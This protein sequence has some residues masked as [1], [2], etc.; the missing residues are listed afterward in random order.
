MPRA[1]RSNGAASSLGS[2]LARDARARRRQ[3]RAARVRVRN[4]RRRAA[5]RAAR[6]ATCRRRGGAFEWRRS[7]ATW[8]SAQRN[9]RSF[10]TAQGEARPPS[11]RCRKV[12][13][14][15]RSTRTRRA[16]W[17][18][19]AH[20]AAR[21]G[22]GG[23]GMKEVSA[24][25][26]KL[27]ARTDW[28]F[29][30]LD[31]TV[32]ALPQGE[33]RVAVEIAGDEVTAAYRFVFVPEEW[34]RLRGRPARG[35]RFSRSSSSVVFGSLL[36]TAGVFGIIAWSRRQ[37]HA[38]ALLRGCG[39]DARR[40]HRARDQRVAVAPGVAAD[41]RAADDHGAGRRG[42]SGSWAWRSSRRSSVCRWA[43][44]RRT[45]PRSGACRRRRAAAWRGRGAL[46]RGRG[47]RRRMAH[48]PGV[49]AVPRH[50][51]V[52]HPR[53]GVTGGPRIRSCRC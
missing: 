43:T 1:A 16:A 4:R 9:G 39:V 38:A 22:A 2:T 31:T 41:N 32:P 27:K 17:R 8:P 11:T 12:A 46:R 24:R 51:G 47:R 33:P 48:D 34:Q 21:R 45:E 42:A 49:G 35:T 26:A 3:R 52:R 30:F 37:V 5:A 36:V 14:G 13:P 15:R 20:R 7:R 28:T 19:R 40:V 50:R 23:A 25:P 6:H 10:V 29:T 53:A 18:W 44:P